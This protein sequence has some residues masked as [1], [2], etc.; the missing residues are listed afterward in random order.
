MRLLIDADIICYRVGFASNEDPVEFAL[1]SVDVCL[2]DILMDLGCKPLEGDS[3]Q[4]YL[5]GKGNYREFVAVTAP[6]KGNRVDKAKPIHYDAIRQHLIDAWK[7]VVIDGME[8]D[9]AIAIAHDPYETIIVS[10]DKDFDQLPGVHYN[11]VKKLEYTVTEHE[12]MRFL[13]EQILTGDVADNIKGIR[14]VGPVK[15]KKILKDCDTE[16]DMFKACIKAYEE[17][18]D[19]LYPMARVIENA[20]LLYLLRVEG[21][22][23]VVPQDRSE[24]ITTAA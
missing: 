3:Y 15:A 22:K 21:D 14:G 4:C 23:W 9:D 20:Q 12:A 7:A 13:Y 1:H 24:E 6:Y 5:T 2:M 11:F 17:L 16:Y 18:D 10:I 19:T 8:A